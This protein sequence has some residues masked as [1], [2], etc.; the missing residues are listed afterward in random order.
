MGICMK[1]GFSTFKYGFNGNFFYTTDEHGRAR[2]IAEGFEIIEKEK[3]KE[4]PNFLINGGDF[5]NG[6]PCS[7]KD[8]IKLYRAFAKNN[9]DIKMIFQIGNTEFNYCKNKELNGILSKLKRGNKNISFINYTKDKLSKIYN[10]KKEFCKVDKYVI[11]NDKVKDNNGNLI[12]QKILLTGTTDN[13]DIKLDEHKKTFDEIIMP[14]IKKEN[15]DKIM[16]ITHLRYP[17]RNNFTEFIKSKNLPQKIVILSAHSHQSV[18]DIDNPQIKT[19]AP[20]P[21][22]Y[23]IIKME[24]RKDSID[25]PKFTPKGFDTSLDFYPKNF[26]KLEEKPRINNYSKFLEKNGTLKPIG[27]LLVNPTNREE[28]NY[29]IS[30]TCQIGTLLANKLKEQTKSDFAVITTMSIRDRL[31]EAGQLLTK[32][33]IKKVIHENH[34]LDRMLLSGQNVL[35]MFEESLREQDKG[36]FNVNFLEFSDNV[37]IS[38]TTD[39]NSIK[40]IKQIEVNGEILLDKN[41]EII[42]K[43]KKYRV[44][45]CDYFSTGARK[46]F[47]FLKGKVDKHFKKFN[48]ADSFVEGITEAIKSKQTTF[49]ESVIKNEN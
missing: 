38:R 23:S 14:A 25:I 42:D 43:N 36:I 35:D 28:L 34:N 22:G 39:K 21:M 19:V 24:N 44:S 15:P 8:L 7:P 49:A 47:E 37:K 30:D 2:G 29:K 48:L 13:K 20:L 33:D 40:K 12:S 5:S 1:I 10:S 3:S 41:G 45:T 31:P 16:I 11:L 27:K 32:Y 18:C 17:D 46:G 9:P 26:F 6:T 4:L